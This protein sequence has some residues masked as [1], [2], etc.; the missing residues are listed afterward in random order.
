MARAGAKDRQWLA[1][2]VAGYMV[3]LLGGLVLRWIGVLGWTLLIESSP[4]I[5]LSGGL[6]GSNF[7]AAGHRESGGN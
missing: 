7:R 5:A 1:V 4:I 2:F 6:W 3:G